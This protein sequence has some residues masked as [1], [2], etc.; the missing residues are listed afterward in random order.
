MQLI[1][2]TVQ[3]EVFGKGTVTSREQN[4][5]TVHFSQGN[6]SFLYPEAFSKY[7][8]AQNQDLQ[9]RI[10][11]LFHAQQ[12]EQEAKEHA[13]ME[14]WEKE[15]ALRS[16]HIPTRSQCAFD[17]APQ[18]DIFASW[19][20]SPGC[21][22]SGLSKGEPRIPDR[23]GPNSLCVL[24]RVADGESEAQRKIIGLAMADDTFSGADCTDGVIPTHRIYRM[25]L[26]PE[27]QPLFWPFF[28]AD[29]AKRKWG[30][31][32]MK[33]LPNETGE[34]IL[35]RICAGQKTEAATAFYHYFCELNHL[36]PSSSVQ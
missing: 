13:E 29:P 26:N 36:E 14:K 17:I 3:H 4:I 25:A 7:L 10:L 15:T 9:Q 22:L 6:R 1:G 32:V 18:E 19:Q 34:L 11:D 33:Y 27:D 23:M 2:Q 12:Q 31:T 35:R 21:Y 24:T 5:L 20:L 16:L 28:T 8:V 30:K